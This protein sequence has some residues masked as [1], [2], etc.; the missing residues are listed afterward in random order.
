LIPPE[1]I[2]QVRQQADI[3]E[4]LSE[5]VT[6]LRKRGA[7]YVGLS[8]FTNEKTP[9]FTVSP[10]KQIFKDFSS[11]RGGSVFKF[12]QEYL[13]ISFPEAVEIVADKVGIKIPKSGKSQA[14]YSKAEQMRR[15]LEDTAEYYHQNLHK[16]EIAYNY[17]R[18]R[19]FSQD[20]I[21]TFQ[22]GYSLDDWESSYK[23]LSQ[24][25]YQTE[26]L[27]NVGI[28]K[29]TKTGNWYDYYKGRV[30]FPIRNKLGRTVGFGGR[31]LK[32]DKDSPKYLNTP[33]TQLYDKSRILYGLFEA[34][35]EIRNKDFCILVE[36]YADVV[37]LYQEGVKNVVASSGTA[38]TQGQLDLLKN[39]TNKLFMIYDA[40]KAGINAAEK[41][42][43]L[44]IRKG[45]EI[46]V[47]RLPEGEDPDSIVQNH[48]TK[49]FNQYLG[50]A[51]DFVKFKK[52]VYE[53][54]YGEMGV[55]HRSE[56]IR[57]LISLIKAIPDR[58]QHSHYINR[59]ETELNL[60][61]LESEYFYDELIKA[62][63]PDFIE[64]IKVAD[65]KENAQ[66]IEQKSFQIE[67]SEKAILKYLIDNF[68]N[69]DA[70]IENFD[71]SES[72]F[73][74]QDAQY[75][76]SLISEIDEHD[77]NDF[78]DN[79]DIEQ[80]EKNFILDLAIHG[81]EI[82]QKLL[83][84]KSIEIHSDDEMIKDCILNLKLL[85]LDNEYQE[86]ISKLSNKNDENILLRLSQINE[87]KEN[88]KEK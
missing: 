79:S 78:I 14:E 20:T 42:L 45:F 30:I 17:T 70:K 60:S 56:L 76:F 53:W 9:S 58:F 12:L 32:N 72:T 10:D 54:K 11:G 50:K 4:I 18:K 34:K 74:S 86:L 44:A 57:S 31:S 48:G 87:L 23:F 40:D 13:S 49:T 39:Y 71:I 6:N 28:L 29:K 19:G 15:A 37:S 83:E 73:L 43:E 24:K 63:K 52:W 65:K 77:L 61:R 46:K 27:E 82:N 69:I 55:T 66:L 16:N 38:L 62:N 64:Q 35:E 80:S 1:I 47:V 36:G 81:S 2:E 51:D 85:K 21:S 41:G 88:L 75:F 84:G 26:I 68:D 3:V 8:P 5:Y 59:V 67:E 25:G 22:L 33:Q 7:N